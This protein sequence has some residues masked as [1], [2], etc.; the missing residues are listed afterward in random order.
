MKIHPKSAKCENLAP[1]KRL[2]TTKQEK[3]KNNQQLQ[4]KSKI[5]KE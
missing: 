4:I 2:K 1:Q 5:K 3:S